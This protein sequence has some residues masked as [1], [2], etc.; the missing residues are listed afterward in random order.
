MC[1]TWAT[2]IGATLFLNIHTR[3]QIEPTRVEW[4]RDAARIRSRMYAHA[5]YSNHVRLHASHR[6]KP[7]VGC[8]RA[9]WEPPPAALQNEIM[10]GLSRYDFSQVFGGG[11][12][13]RGAL[14]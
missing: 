6:R 8:G 9:A 12:I 2:R 5:L 4:L 3:L 13:L 11:G 7:S 10:G 14:L 1:V